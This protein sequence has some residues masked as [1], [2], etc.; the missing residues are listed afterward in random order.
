MGPH[1]ESPHKILTAGDQSVFNRI[2]W[3]PSGNRIAYRLRHHEQ[4]KNDVSIQSCDITGANK[5]TILTD[6]QMTDFNWA[7][8]GRLVFSRWAGSQCE[9]CKPKSW[10]KGATSSSGGHHRHPVRRVLQR[11]RVHRHDG[12]LHRRILGALH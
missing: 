8:P 9:T 3:S 7:S 1:G 10:T 4:N 5:K 2:A 12:H 11:I 6:S